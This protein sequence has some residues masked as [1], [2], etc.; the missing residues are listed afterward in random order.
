MTH[1]ERMIRTLRG[2]STDMMPW[3]PR[4]DLWYNAHKRAGT[5][6]AKYMNAS[7]RDITD[8]EGFGFHAIVPHFKDLRDPADDLHR[9]LGIYNLWSAGQ[10]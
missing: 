4:L 6:P 10:V 9:A 7:L 2:E 1:K 5:L 8:E 3:A